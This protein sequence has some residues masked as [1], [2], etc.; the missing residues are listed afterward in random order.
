M[1]LWTRP[2]APCDYQSK[3]SRIRGDSR[4]E[5]QQ[6]TNCHES[7]QVDVIRPWP[8]PM[9]GDG[10]NP[11]NRVHPRPSKAEMIRVHEAD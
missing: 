8:W 10:E 3:A 9:P 7:D 1:G 5:E 2:H 4:Q 6:K 11:L